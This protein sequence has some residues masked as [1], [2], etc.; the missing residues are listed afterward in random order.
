LCSSIRVEV[1]GLDVDLGD[2]GVRD[3]DCL[4]VVVVVETA[5]DGEPCFGRGG[6]DQLDDHGMGEQRFA[7][8]VPRDDGKEAMFDAF[9]LLVP[10]GWW[11]TVIAS[12]D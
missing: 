7:A 10:G 9:H 8:P 11:V 12:P 1:I 4:G 5:M 6:G 3:L 2:F